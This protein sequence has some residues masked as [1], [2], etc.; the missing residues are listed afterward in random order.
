MTEEK[1]K[2]IQAMRPLSPH[3]TIYKPQLTSMLSITHRITGF[4]LFCGIITMSWIF[5]SFIYFPDFLSDCFECINNN[6]ILSFLLKS[7]SLFWIF[8][9]FYHLLNGI[10]HLFWDAG[11]GFNLKDTYISG[12]IVIV[13]SIGLTL[14]CVAFVNLNNENKIIIDETV[15][16]IESK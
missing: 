7:M 14:F 3:L 8:S 9:L 15:I 1:Y 4:Y 13:L 5:F 11:F 16:E 6:S 10:R 12:K 2:N